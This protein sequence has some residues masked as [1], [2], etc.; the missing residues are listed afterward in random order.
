M[1]KLNRRRSES[2]VL[3]KLE[4]VKANLFI[5]LKKTKEQQVVTKVQNNKNAKI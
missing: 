5:K 4:K 1:Y 3:Y 2:Q